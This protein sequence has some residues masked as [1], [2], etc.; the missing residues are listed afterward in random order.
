MSDDEW[1]RDVASVEAAVEDA[2]DRLDLE[3]AE[4][5][6]STKEF[7]ST[8]YVTATVNRD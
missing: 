8:A 7:G 4:T 3:T 2:L 5:H 6:T 1:L